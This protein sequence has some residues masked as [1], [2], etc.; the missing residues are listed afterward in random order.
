M[1]YCYTDETSILDID[2]LFDA[3]FGTSFKVLDRS[4]IIK[5]D[6]DLI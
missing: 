4:S 1:F 2:T 5:V 3:L 6:A